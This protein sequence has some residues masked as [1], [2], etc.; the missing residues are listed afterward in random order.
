VTLGIIVNNTQTVQEAQSQINTVNNAIIS[1]M[2]KLGIQKEDIS[3]SNYSISPNYNYEIGAKE[4]DILTQFLVESVVMSLIGGLIGIALGISGAFLISL[5][6]NIPFVVSIPAIIIAVGYQLL[7]ELCLGHILQGV[8][9]NYLL[10]M[11]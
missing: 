9:Q 3:T 1:A 2:E 7:S 4:K 8:Q 6:A 5:V 10:S 11:L